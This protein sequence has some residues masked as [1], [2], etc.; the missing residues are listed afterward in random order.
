MSAFTLYPYLIEELNQLLDNPHDKKIKT[1]ITKLYG[2]SDLD[3]NELITIRRQH[4]LREKFRLS[5]CLRY[6]MHLKTTEDRYM[7][8]GNLICAKSHK[9]PPSKYERKCPHFEVELPDWL[10][11][12]K[13]SSSS[14]H[15]TP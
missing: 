5:Q 7:I 6:C 14:P 8:T 9:E 1:Q 2:I 4:I 11:D 13:S 3:I 10:K 15:L 12:K